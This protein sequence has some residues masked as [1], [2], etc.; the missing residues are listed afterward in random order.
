ME[1]KDL[2][3]VFIIGIR[4]VGLYQVAGKRRTC[5]WFIMSIRYVGLC[6]AA[7]ANI[8]LLVVCSVYLVFGVIPS[9]SVGKKGSADGL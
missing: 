6:L 3:V 5:W 8:A 9:C 2:L 1:K 7:V 4:Y